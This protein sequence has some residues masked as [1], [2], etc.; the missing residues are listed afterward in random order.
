MTFLAFTALGFVTRGFLGAGAAVTLAIP[1]DFDAAGTS[2]EL[3]AFFEVVVVVA[4]G[5]SSA[6]RFFVAVDV[7]AMD[8]FESFSFLEAGALSSS[9]LRFFEAAGG[10]AAFFVVAVFFAGGAFVGAVCVLVGA[11][12]LRVVEAV[13]ALFGG[14]FVNLFV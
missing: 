6:L 14:I 8:G 1:P 2:L 3:L 9:A 11:A 5:S 13:V 10:A 4:G 12:L 7:G